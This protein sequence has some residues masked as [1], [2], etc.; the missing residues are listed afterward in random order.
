MEFVIGTAIALAGLALTYLGFR[1]QRKSMSREIE[2][3]LWEED[4]RTVQGQIA[5]NNASR[6]TATVDIIRAVEPERTK[7]AWF[8]TKGS[9]IGPSS[10][11][12]LEDEDV[13]DEHQVRLIVDPGK[14]GTVSFFLRLPYAVTTLDV[15]GVECRIHPSDRLFGFL[16]KE[17]RKV[18]LPTRLIR[19]V[20]KRAG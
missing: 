5:L 11:R 7:I 16:P 10:T 20:Y 9:V 18:S 4:D 6:E 1:E 8:P 14:V 19:P 2:L 17:W 3:R 15:I 12:T 13:T